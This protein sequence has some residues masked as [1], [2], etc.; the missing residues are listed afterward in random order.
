[1]P[2][3]KLSLVFD[4]DTLGPVAAKLF[5]LSKIKTVKRRGKEHENQYNFSMANSRGRT[6][7]ALFVAILLAGCFLSLEQRWEAFDEQM[8]QEIGVK[9]KDY[10]VSEWGNPTNRVKL[11]NGGSTWTWEFRGYDGVQGWPPEL[12]FPG[13]IA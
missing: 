9:I 7:K 10:Y 11:A 1:V 2:R 6:S 12:P 4:P 8:L 13:G 3:I 5:D